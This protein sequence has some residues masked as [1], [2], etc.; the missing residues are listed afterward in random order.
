LGSPAGTRILVLNGLSSG[1][2]I[3]VKGVNS[4]KDGQIVGPRVQE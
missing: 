3:I 1:D 4:I 2:E